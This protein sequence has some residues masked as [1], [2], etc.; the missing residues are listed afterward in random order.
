MI[1]QYIESYPDPLIL[2]IWKRSASLIEK[3]ETGSIESQIWVQ[4][5][6]DAAST[7]SVHYLSLRLMVWKYLLNVI[8]ETDAEWRVGESYKTLGTT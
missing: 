4:L 2:K 1:Q 5:C 8:L 7:P 3:Y 6:I